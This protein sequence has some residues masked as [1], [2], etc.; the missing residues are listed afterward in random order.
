MLEELDERLAT[1]RYLFGAS[2]VETDWRLFVTLTPH[3]REG[4]AA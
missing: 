4:V 3:H 2:L 1:R